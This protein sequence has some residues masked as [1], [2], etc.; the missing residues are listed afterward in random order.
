MSQSTGIDIKQSL[1]DTVIA[2]LMALIVFGPIVGV[3]LD[4]YDFNMQTENVAWLVGVVM[5]GRFEI[6][7]AHV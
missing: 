5:V 1:V 4:G 7:R 6:G 3:L 2:G